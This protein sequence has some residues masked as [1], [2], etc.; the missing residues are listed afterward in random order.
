MKICVKCG[1][2]LGDDAK[3]CVK[4]GERVSEPVY[5]EPVVENDNLNE[6]EEI[7]EAIDKGAASNDNSDSD[8]DATVS[9][10]SPAVAASA[11]ASPKVETPVVKSQPVAQPAYVAPPVVNN[12]AN[13][14]QLSAKEEKAAA[15]AAAKAN[16]EASK[17]ALRADKAAEKAAR[18]MPTGNSVAAIAA[19]VLALFALFNVFNVIAIPVAAVVA[20]INIFVSIAGIA[21]TGLGRASGRGLAVTA[22]IL[23]LIT[24]V[25]IALM[26]VGMFMA[27]ESVI[28]SLGD[29]PELIKDIVSSGF[30]ILETL[31][32]GGFTIVAEGTALN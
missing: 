11:A 22:L 18:V 28:D 29:V 12:G 21:N 10:K 30:E 19:F 7:D 9:V 6:T 3:F 14:P 16:K 32:E 23:S 27:F 2:Q 1:A 13:I 25:T 5:E 8:L 4:C 24:L 31:G 26:V 17:A 20:F 15:K